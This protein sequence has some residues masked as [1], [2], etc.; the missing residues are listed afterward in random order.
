[1]QV[2]CFLCEVRTVCVCVCVCVCIYIYIY[3]YIY[4]CVCVCVC[5]Y[6]YNVDL[7]YSS[8]FSVVPCQYNFSEA[9]CLSSAKYSFLEG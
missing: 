4:I 1:M 6:V 5:V 9:T 3:I 2:L 8:N 7:F